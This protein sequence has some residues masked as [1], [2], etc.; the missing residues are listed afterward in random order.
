[1]E[2]QNQLKL[3]VVEFIIWFSNDLWIQKSP[4]FDE[5]KKWAFYN[6]NNKNY[7][8]VLSIDQKIYDKLFNK[9]I[10]FLME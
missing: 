9:S 2:K 7:L 6:K 1:M 4:S 3:L 8:L 5:F 10:K